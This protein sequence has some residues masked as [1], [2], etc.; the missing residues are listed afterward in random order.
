MI[1]G[2]KLQCVSDTLDKVVL[3]NDG[4]WVFPVMRRA[5]LVRVGGY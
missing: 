1:V 5:R 3:A 2:D 4:H